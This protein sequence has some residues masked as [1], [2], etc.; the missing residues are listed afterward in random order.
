MDWFFEELGDLWT[1]LTTKTFNGFN[2]KKFT[3]EETVQSLG[4][5]KKNM[6]TKHHTEHYAQLTTKS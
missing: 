6:Q 4:Q 2:G 3:C 1:S 5:V